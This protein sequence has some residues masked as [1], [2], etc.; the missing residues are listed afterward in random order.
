MLNNS[1]TFFDL[2]RIFMKIAISS[3]LDDFQAVDDLP[4][5]QTERKLLK[6]SLRIP[7]HKLGADHPSALL[8]GA[9]ALKPNHAHVVLQGA[10]VRLELL[11]L[12]N[13]VAAGAV[14]VLHV[15]AHQKTVSVLKKVRPFV[16]VPGATRAQTDKVIAHIG[17][18][19]GPQLEDDPAERGP[20]HAQ[21]HPAMGELGRRLDRGRNRLEELGLAVRGGERLL[22]RLL[23][24]VQIRDGA[25]GVAFAFALAVVDV[26]VRQFGVDEREISD[27]QTEG[28]G[29]GRMRVRVRVLGGPVHHHGGLDHL[30]GFEH[31]ADVEELLRLRLVRLAGHGRQVV[32]GAVRVRKGRKRNRVRVERGRPVP[33][34]KQIGKQIDQEHVGEVSFLGV[35]LQGGGE[36]EGLL[37]REA[38]L[39]QRGL[40]VVLLQLQKQRLQ[41]A[42]HRVFGITMSKFLSYILRRCVYL[43][44]I[45]NN[46]LSSFILFLFKILT[47]LLVTIKKLLDLRFLE[48]KLFTY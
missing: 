44:K 9:H 45:R 27:A 18:L 47:I 29:D 43:K 36:G 33:S 46:P 26:F 11:L 5:N 38:Q 41:G 23:H 17:R 32:V 3:C 31:I 30:G 7:N 13:G 15:A 42:I 28:G 40:P 4:E 20:V 16:P 12:V 35:L 19:V 2:Y 8:A 1:A 21:D 14:V 24:G 10:Q 39:G 34:E 48:T 22:R 25:R 6:L 37:A